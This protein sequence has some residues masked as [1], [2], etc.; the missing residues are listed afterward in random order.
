MFPFS[1]QEYLSYLIGLWQALPARRNSGQISVAIC[2][3]LEDQV[4]QGKLEMTTEK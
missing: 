2:F 4:Q 1:G 3:S